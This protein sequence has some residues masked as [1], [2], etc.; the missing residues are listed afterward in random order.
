[1]APSNRPPEGLEVSTNL[2]AIQAVGGLIQDE[3][4]AVEF[5]DEISVH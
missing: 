2:G 1:M 5:S 3:W 4:A